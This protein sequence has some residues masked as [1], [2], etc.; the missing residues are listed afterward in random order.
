MAREFSVMPKLG[1]SA[2]SFSLPNQ[3]PNVGASVISLADYQDAPA[4]LITFW[5]NHCPFVIHIKESFINFAQ[6]FSAKE[7]SVVAICSND[8]VSHPDDSP[9]KM[10]LEAQNYNYPFPYL[11]DDSQQT[12]KLYQAAC[13]PDF[14][15]YDKNHKL[16]YC[17]RYDS[18]TPNND[19][20]VTGDSMLK[21][22]D[23]LLSG[24]PP[25]TDQNPSVGC[26]I[27]WK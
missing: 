9:E 17:G 7:L 2:A 10:T 19:Q 27:K 20:P 11:H 1:S 23:N 21:A 16:H 26:S 18:S 5:C 25:L 24:K 6:S 15:L 14:F 3:N 22:V 12:A 8:S 4:L 13:T